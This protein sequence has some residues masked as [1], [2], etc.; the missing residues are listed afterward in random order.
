[1]SEFVV[2]LPPLEL[3]IIGLS[4]SLEQNPL[5]RPRLSP[6]ELNELRQ[7]LDK[8]AGPPKS[9]FGMLVL[10]QKKQDSDYFLF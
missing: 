7:Q 5:L 2:A 1:M 6:T 8:Q 9:P 10:F 4:W 3:W